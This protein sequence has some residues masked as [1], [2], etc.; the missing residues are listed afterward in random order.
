M[1]LMQAQKCSSFQAEAI[2]NIAMAD[3]LDVTSASFEGEFKHPEKLE[4]GLRFNDFTNPANYENK[5]LLLRFEQSTNDTPFLTRLLNQ[6]RRFS[7]MGFEFRTTAT[8]GQEIEIDLDAV[9]PQTLQ[10]V[11]DLLEERP[12]IGLRG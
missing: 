9:G 4:S 10:S 2:M 8:Q 1:R 5:K 12:E 3:G 11:R 7:P 6:A